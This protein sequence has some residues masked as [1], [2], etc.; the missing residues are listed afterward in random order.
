MVRFLDSGIR[1]TEWNLVSVEN[2]RKGTTGGT[3]NREVCIR[4]QR[5]YLLARLARETP[6]VRSFVQQ[7][8][9]VT[10]SRLPLPC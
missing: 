7:I 2:R 4:I 9:L 8:K 10:R 3:T 5:R 6:K 1:P